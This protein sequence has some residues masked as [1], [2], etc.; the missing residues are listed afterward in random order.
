M[1]QLPKF[2]KDCCDVSTRRVG[3]ISVLASMPL[4]AAHTSTAQ[5]PEGEITLSYRVEEAEFLLSLDTGWCERVTGLL[6][7]L[8]AKHPT[9]GSG[10]LTV[11]LPMSIL[12]DGSVQN[13]T[14]N[15]HLKPEVTGGALGTGSDCARQ[16]DREL[17]DCETE[18]VRRD[19]RIYASWREQ[20]KRCINGWEI[21]QDGAV[22]GG[23]GAC[24]GAFG[25]P[26]GV[27]L[28]GIGGIG[29]G[30]LWGISDCYDSAKSTRD[31]DLANSV[32]ERNDCID[33]AALN[34]E[35]CLEDAGL[36]VG[37]N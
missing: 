35:R 5:T 3:W 1:L 28:C 22:G 33:D 32:V 13:L 15:H 9:S 29:V 25:G 18:R 8:D 36:G 19:A 27:A 17:T 34:F 23:F 11:V 26:V 30:V 37:R 4:P 24:A 10:A 16:F 12:E 14:A 7:H 31:R 20:L 2:G 21:F 6:M